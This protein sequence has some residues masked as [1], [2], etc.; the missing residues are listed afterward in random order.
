MSERLRVGIVGAGANTRLRHVPGFRAIAGVELAGVVNRSPESTA[1][2]ASEFDIP[3]TYRD[4]RELVSDPDLDAV[5]IGTWPNLHCE[6]TRAAL[7]AG[8]HVLTEA[9][10]AR[11]L[12]EARQMLEASQARPDLVA[13]IVP[14]P[15][16]LEHHEAL[17]RLIAD[18]F[19]GEL[20]EFVV[21]SADDSFHDE[22]KPLHWR[23]DRE[24]SGVN[25]LALGI[26]HEAATRWVPSPDR[27]FAQARARFFQSIVMAFCFPAFGLGM[28]ISIQLKTQFASPRARLMPGFAGPHLTIVA[29]ITFFILG[30]PVLVGWLKIGLSPVGP[31]S[32]GL[33]VA[34]MFAWQSWLMSN[35]LTLPL[36]IVWFSLMFGAQTEFIGGILGRWFLTPE[37]TNV[38]ITILAGSVG[39]TILLAHR[40]LSL[41]EENTEYGL[42]IPAGGFRALTSR[43]ANR[44][45]EKLAG[46]IIAQSRFAPW[47]LDRWFELVMRWLPA[48]G[49]VRRVALYQI[50]HGYGALIALPIVCVGYV[51]L[52][53][54]IVHNEI[55]QGIA[56]ILQA[57]FM[58]HFVMAGVGSIWLQH[59]K[60]HAAELLRPQSRNEFV[61]GL[62]CGVGGDLAYATFWILV[63]QLVACLQGSAAFGRTPTETAVIA[64]AVSVGYL[65]V[66]AGV[67]LFILSYQNFWVYLGT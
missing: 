16:G 46:R 11:N 64:V 14:S 9:R 30:P 7:A 24:I 19:L 4:W 48:T 31:L 41:H 51:F 3:K 21:I 35:L 33:L 40:V 23:Q 43:A 67:L 28:L 42:A 32:L 63:A 22:T 60:W 34:V 1:R 45:V 37:T 66:S 8:K 57:L 44:E 20:R 2:A 27:V 49:I 15:F 58:S 5:M 59:G 17:T 26:I 13:Q 12:A 18:G 10:M 39:A 62:F 36:L 52:T 6:V 65:L 38:A 53:G 55:S 56:V 29:L 61:S 47:A 50:V 54:W 25:T